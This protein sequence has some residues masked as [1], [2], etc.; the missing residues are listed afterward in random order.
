MGAIEK[1]IQLQV[2]DPIVATIIMVF[3]IILIHGI[4]KGLKTPNNKE[5]Y[6]YTT[7]KQITET[8]KDS[9]SD[10]IVSDVKSALKTMGFKKDIID[11]AVN[12]ALKESPTSTR[13]V[14]LKESLKQAAA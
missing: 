12:A 13:E 2:Y 4:I 5:E 7:E 8:E 6:T 11:N 14:L 3:V 10:N 1:L 9:R